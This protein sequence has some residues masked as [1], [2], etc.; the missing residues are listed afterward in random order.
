MS[1]DIQASEF[2]TAFSFA[3]MTAVTAMI[4]LPVYKIT[5]WNFYSFVFSWFENKKV[6]PMK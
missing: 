3:F 1:A 2:M 5:M 6:Q 4:V